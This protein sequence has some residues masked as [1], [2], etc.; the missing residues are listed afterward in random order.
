ML[1]RNHKRGGKMSDFDTNLSACRDYPT[2]W[3]YPLKGREAY[4]ASRNAINICNECSVRVSCLEYAL[5]N[6]THGIWGGMRE[7]EREIER[8]RRGIQLSPQAFSAMSAQTMRVS[9]K[10][11]QLQQE[12]VIYQ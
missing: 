12:S 1:P 10:L 4:A 9:R 2:D 5:V 11:N 8:R 3:W 7:S 6:E